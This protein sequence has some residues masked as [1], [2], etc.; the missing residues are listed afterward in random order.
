MPAHKTKKASSFT[1]FAKKKEVYVGKRRLW[2]ALDRPM[3]SQLL[4]AY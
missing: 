3:A 2:E 1:A 4:K